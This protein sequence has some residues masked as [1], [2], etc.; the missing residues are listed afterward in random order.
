VRTPGGGRPPPPRRRR[1]CRR[2]WSSTSLGVES[3]GRL[4][5]RFC[6]FLEAALLIDFADYV[7]C[8]VRLREHDLCL[9]VS[10]SPE[11]GPVAG[12]PPV[13]LL[14]PASR[15]GC[16]VGSSVSA[17]LSFRRTP[18]GGGRDFFVLG[19]G[20][21]GGLATPLCTPPALWPRFVDGR[22][23]FSSG[24]SDRLLAA[25]RAGWRIW[26]GFVGWSPRR[27]R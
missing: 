23:G 10:G 24:G 21:S 9:S 19:W 27:L 6:K 17:G 7:A 1:R 20:R 16:C 3:C 18:A 12:F 8:L 22:G 11:G 13:G 14:E 2:G 26:R 25:S 5:R 4:K 15:R